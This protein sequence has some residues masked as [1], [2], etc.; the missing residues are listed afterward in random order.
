MKHK[1][2][3]SLSNVFII[4]IKGCYLQYLQYLFLPKTNF[5]FQSI[6]KDREERL[7]MVKDRQ[8]EERQRKLEE[9]KNQAI[10]AQKYRE[11][12]E[13]ERKRRMEELRHKELDRKQQV[14]LTKMKFTFVVVIIWIVLGG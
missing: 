1:K 10:A 8:N 6:A 7:R 4:H 12:K 11:Q 13:D 2:L 14:K 5:Y 3:I 9:L